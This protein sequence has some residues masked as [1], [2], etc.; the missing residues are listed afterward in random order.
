MFI[1]NWIAFAPAKIVAEKQRR[2]DLESNNNN[3]NNNKILF[4]KR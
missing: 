1:L 3:N 2:A 4:I